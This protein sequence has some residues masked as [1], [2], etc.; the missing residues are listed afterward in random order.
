[1]TNI[2]QSINHLLSYAEEKNLIEKTDRLY[3]QNQLLDLLRRAGFPE[4]FPPDTAPPLEETLEHLAAYAAENEII[5]DSPGAR[6]SFTTRVMGLFTPRPSEVIR[7]F[8]RRYAESP[9]R[10]TDYF[11]KLSEDCD[12]IRTARVARDVKWTTP[13]Q[14]GTLDITI[15]LSKPEKDPLD[16]AAAKSAPQSGYPKCLLCAENEGYA[17]TPAHPARQNLRLIP[18]TLG[19][20]RWYLQYS[21]YVYY[22][23]HCIILS[24]KHA[25]M[26]VTTATFEKL[27][28]FV[29]QYPHYF[30]GSNADLPIVGGSILS[31]EHYQ[32]GRYTFALENAPV[33]YT[34]HFPGVTAGIVKWPMSVIRL[35]GERGAVTGLAAKI[36]TLWRSYTDES[37]EIL[38]QTTEPHN[39]I[40]PIARRSGEDYVLDL[41]LRNNRTSAQHP[42]GIFHPHEELHHIKKENIGLIEVMG[43][44]ILP[45]RLIGEMEAVKAEIL[46][47]KPITGPHKAW[48][49]SWASKANK[50]NIDEIIKEEIGKVFEKVLEHAGVFARNAEAFRRFMQKIG[51]PT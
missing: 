26:T 50:D 30:A 47:K 21:P 10:A 20:E 2:D 15:N 14:Y 7:E 11:Y 5:D 44:A 46:Q 9:V 49:E 8:E 3:C 40:T 1:M 42:L 13:T 45:P 48:A 12:Y 17:G 27:L 34:R 6:D 29:T 18:I 51:E 38:S 41:V 25:P 22:N 33:E 35:Q 23:E 39:T 31:H 43:L 4:A 28:D 37:A 36:L 24:E 32:G 19:G 16:I